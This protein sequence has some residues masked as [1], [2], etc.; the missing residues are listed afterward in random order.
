M[1]L[2]KKVDVLRFSDDSDSSLGI[3]Q[4]DGKTVS[5]SVEDQEQKGQKIKGETR[6]SNGKYKLGL[7]ADGGFHQRYLNR[8][9]SDFHKGMLCVYTD[10][11]W[12]LNCPD[13][14]NFQYI[15]IHAGNTDD[16]TAG[17]LLPNLILDLDKH[18]G[19]RSRDAYEKIYPILRD[20]I[21]KSDNGYI[22]IEYSDIEPGK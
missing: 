16:N 4:L 19:G 20:S 2:I 5:G 13:G 14:K 7:R 21:L 9:K 15:L 6:V 17:C 18:T 11:N 12:V 22:E 10:D 3:I 8:Y 1:S